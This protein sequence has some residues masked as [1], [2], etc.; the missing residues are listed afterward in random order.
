[1]RNKNTALILAS[2]LAL[3]AVG[4]KAQ[5]AETPKYRRSSL[6]M[7]LVDANNFDRKDVVL[8]SWNSYPFPDKYDKHNIPFKTLQLSPTT[9]DVQGIVDLTTGKADVQADIDKAIKDN[10]IG[11]QL[12]AAWFNRS[13]NGKFDMKLIQQRGHYNATEL[14]ASVAKQ[15]TRGMAALA[16]AGEELI[17]N[18][19][20][21]FTRFVF[22]KNEPVAAL[23]SKIAKKEAAERLAGKPQ[24][25]IDAA[26][27]TA[28]AAYEA[29]KD[30]QTLFSKTWLYKLVW[31]DSIAA[32][33][34]NV[35]DNP[36]AFDKLDF[37]LELVGVQTNSSVLLLALDGAEAAIHKVE[38]RNIDKVFAELQQKYDVFKP[39]IPILT[40][41]PLTAQI[42]M[43]EGLKGGEKFQVLE[44]TQDPATGRTKYVVVGKTKVDKKLVWDNRYNAGEAP[45]VEVTDKEGNPIAATTFKKV[46]KAQP[47]MLL[48]QVK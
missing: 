6:A 41:D 31:N 11:N 4:A 5:T 2:A 13:A 34:Y 24:M 47:G 42:G 45:E 3:G 17:N 16:D 44:M 23:I 40:S 37:Q 27:K 21:S 39:K 20:I 12:V 26:Y 43:K 30:G 7:V 38:V 14:E 25:A 35:W 28:D 46:K 48:K 33:F 22:F 36:A 8:R 18:T 15:Q 9:I 1:M 29:A 10:K 19:F 32:E